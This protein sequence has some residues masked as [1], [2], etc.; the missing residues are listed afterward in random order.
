M[1]LNKHHLGMLHT[2]DFLAGEGDYRQLGLSCEA[3]KS[4]IREFFSPIKKHAHTGIVVGVDADSFR[5]ITKDVKKH[6][7]PEVF[8]FQRVIKLVSLIIKDW[9]ARLG[10]SDPEPYQLFFDDAEDYAMKVY[11]FLCMLR[12][13]DSVARD[14]I[15]C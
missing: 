12:R 5:N 14:R 7:R 8:C 15:G 2:A 13:V 11:K 4:I 1:L 10:W 9:E 6:I 3:R